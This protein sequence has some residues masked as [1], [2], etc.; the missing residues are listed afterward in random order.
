MGT[1]RPRKGLRMQSSGE[2][3]AGMVRRWNTRRILSPRAEIRS[4]ILRIMTAGSPPQLSLV[5]AAYNDWVALETCLTSV[6][7][8]RNAPEFEVLVVDDGSESEAPAS[9][10]DKSRRLQLRVIRQVHSGIATARNRGVREARG[11]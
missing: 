8:Q 4:V 9:V 1:E 11:D 3:A 5:I 10:T 6:A 2:L 7:G